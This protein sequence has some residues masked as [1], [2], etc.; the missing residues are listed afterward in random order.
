MSGLGV[1]LVPLPISIIG[2]TCHIKTMRETGPK[3]EVEISPSFPQKVKRL[4]KHKF[5]S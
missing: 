5:G 3:V 2:L 4:A 1:I